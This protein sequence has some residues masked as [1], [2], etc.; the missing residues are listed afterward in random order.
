LR[1]GGG[2]SSKCEKN[3]VTGSLREKGVDA[4][5]TE[6]TLGGGRHPKKKKGSN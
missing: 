1:Q 4:L 2:Q 6:I 3:A 5:E